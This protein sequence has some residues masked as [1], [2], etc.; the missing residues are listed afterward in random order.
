MKI[1]HTDI[2]IF[3]PTFNA[4][5]YL[6]EILKA[7]YKQQIDKV[8]EV[9][10]IDS[11]S[12]DDTLDIIERFP[13]VRLHKIPNSEYGH[14]KTRQLAARMAEGDIVVYLSHDATPSHKRW[15]YEITKPFEIS[16]KIVGVMG[17]Q[18]PRQKCIPM[19]KYDINSIF[20]K[21]GPDFGTTLFYKDTFIEN[22]AVYD[23]VRFYSDVN[24]AARK[25][26]LLGSVPFRDV[27]YAEDQLFG[28]DV[29]EAGLIKVYAPRGS[30]IHSN[31]LKLAEYN[32]RVFDEVYGLRKG[33]ALIAV[34]SRF[35]LLSGTTKG[36]LRDSV[37]ISLDKKYTFK[38]KLYWLA[39]N[40]LFHLQK[41]R[42]YGHALKADISETT[43]KN[44][45]LEHSRRNKG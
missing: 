28:E 14:G 19:M 16:D 1:M 7:I 22:Q 29:L 26:V 38:R 37:R 3:I 39:V 5:M 35:E 13:E 17:K 9:L 11:G 33:G 23:T 21:F 44:K 43:I 20:R 24:S 32:K 42:G 31:E 4:G 41:W 15:L 34:P 45:S 10:I 27:A 30:V 40:P 25:S 8:F 12:T 18:I 36:I 2:T 6:K